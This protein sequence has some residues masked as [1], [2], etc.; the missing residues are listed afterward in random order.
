MGDSV[1]RLGALQFVLGLIHLL[2]ALPQ[3]GGRLIQFILKFRHFEHGQHLTFLHPVSHV[4]IDPLHI[5][6]DL[7]VDVDFLKGS[8]FRRDTQTLGEVGAR[9]L[10]HRYTHNFFALSGLGAATLIA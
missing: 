10:N 9:N 5:P 1:V 3:R 2:L 8:E 4:H 7:G 6:G